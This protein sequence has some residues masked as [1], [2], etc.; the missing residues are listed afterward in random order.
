MATN[1]TRKKTTPILTAGATEATPMVDPTDP[2][3]NPDDANLPWS[4]AWLANRMARNPGAFVRVP[5]DDDCCA[6]LRCMHYVNTARQKVR[7]HGA[8]KSMGVAVSLEDAT[9]RVSGLLKA[10]GQHN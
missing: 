1:T 8:A 2:D 6:G 3:L 5:N 9:L 7:G 4:K 10:L